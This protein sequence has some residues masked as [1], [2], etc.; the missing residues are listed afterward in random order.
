M[1]RASLDRHRLAQ[2]ALEKAEAGRFPVSREDLVVALP[3]D[4]SHL[5]LVKASRSWRK[6]R[7]Q[8]W[9]GLSHL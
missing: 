8:F 3:S 5:P 1:S 9:S 4:E 7:P 2:R 6:V